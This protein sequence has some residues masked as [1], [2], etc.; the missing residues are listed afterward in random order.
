MGRHITTLSLHEGIESQKAF[1]ISIWVYNLSMSSTKFSILLQYLRI[2]PQELFRKACYITMVIV[3][4]YSCWT[5]FSA[6]FACWPIS[7]F[8]NQLA[9]PTGGHCL[10]RFA[11]WFANAGINIATDIG[12][13]I[14]P[15][16]VLKDLE[17]PRRQRIALMIVFGLGGLY[18]QSDRLPPQWFF[19]LTLL[20]A[21]ALSVFSVW[22]RYMSSLAPQTLR[23]RTHLL[24]SG[25]VWRST[26]AYF[27]LVYRRFGRALRESF[28]SCWDPFA[29]HPTIQAE[30]RSKM[31]TKVVAPAMQLAEALRIARVAGI[32]AT[33]T[34]GRC[35][36]TR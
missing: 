25:A 32:P 31:R 12:I 27:V 21:L 16:R 20:L 18:V 13:G 9:E 35:L 22:S 3:G 15:L 6:V 8:W 19:S 26:L 36:P 24:R 10:N 34:L 7:Y 29:R 23:G 5:F 11:V 2:F 1:Y 14:L 30:M 17:M 33:A 28:R 4:I